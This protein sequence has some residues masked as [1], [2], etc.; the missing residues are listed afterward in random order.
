[1]S[2]RCHLCREHVNG[3][4]IRIPVL[5]TASTVV[6]TIKGKPVLGKP[7][8]EIAREVS[9]CRRCNR[10]VRAECDRGAITETAITVVTQRRLPR[11]EP[12]AQVA[13]KPVTP[14]Y[15]DNFLF[16]PKE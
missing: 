10:E 3:P 14:D 7:R 4:M 6:A 16:G 15:D 2:Y 11:A 1:M 5:R 13:A 8:S 12:V 9:S